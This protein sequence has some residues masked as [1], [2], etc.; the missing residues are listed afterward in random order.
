MKTWK[1]TLELLTEEQKQVLADT[2]IYGGWGDC[3][4]TFVNEDGEDVERYCYGYITNHAKDGG[5][6]SGRKLSALFRSLYSKVET[7][8]YHSRSGAGEIICHYNN[9]WDDGSGDVLFIR[10]DVCDEAE[11]W[12]REYNKQ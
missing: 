10:G 2:I 3:D 11:A 7:K 4:M 6:F 8:R 5:H 1:E 9:W 12:A